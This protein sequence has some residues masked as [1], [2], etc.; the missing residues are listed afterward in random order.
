MYVRLTLLSIALATAVPAAAQTFE[1]AGIRAQGMAG[2]DD[3]SATWWNPA[4][5]A[6]GAYFNGIVEFDHL[7][8]P[9]D[10]ADPGGARRTQIGGVSA[11][12]P[13]LGLSYYHFRVSEIRPNANANALQVPSRQDQGPEAPQG[14]VLQS[15]A[16]HQVGVTVGQS[17]GD[18]LVLGTTVKLLSGSSAS[19]VAA[20]ATLD[21]AAQLE[22]E[23][24]FT[25]SFDVGAIVKVGP[26]NAAIVVRNVTEPSFGDGTARMSLPRDVRV[27]VSGT[28]E[29][30]GGPAALTF[31][32][33][34][35]LTVTHGA[36]GDLR[37]LAAGAESWWFHR[38]V[39]VRAGVSGNTVGAARLGP[40][41]GA[42]IA[43]G[44]GMYAEA[45]VTGG[46]DAS[47]RGW[48]IGFRVTF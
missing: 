28:T 17:L 7:D 15:L 13:S 6:G 45:A 48:G 10:E 32:A 46:A 9:P 36:G 8:E 47:R 20:G 42:S 27:G 37:H 14:V 22:G 21:D 41:V 5:L 1:S 18:H 23:S 40:S 12:I 35:D 44:S 3:S 31:A 26:A 34:A 19:S 33:D 11:A 29:P 30:A 4:G 2:A 43:V 16:V 38:R 25:A 24:S 39:G